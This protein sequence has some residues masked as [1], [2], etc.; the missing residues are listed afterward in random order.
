MKTLSPIGLFGRWFGPLLAQWTEPGSATWYFR[1]DWIGMICLVFLVLLIL[2][3]AFAPYVT[4]YPEQGRGEPNITERFLAPNSI[5]IMGTDSLGRDVW[6]RILFGARISLSI[7][8]TVVIIAVVL[9]VTLG[10][11]AGYFGGWIDEILMRIT[12]IFLAF[13]PLL[14]AIT[15]AAVL[16]PKTQNTIVAIALTW[17]PWYTRIVRGQVVSVRERDFVKAA[18]VIGVPDRIIIRRH[19]IPN[20]MSSVLVQAMLDL[21]A[22]ILTA[23]ALSFIGLGTQPP[24]ADWGVMVNEGRQYLLSGRWWLAIFPGAAIFFT[25]MALNLMGDGIRDASDPRTRGGK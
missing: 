23:T 22:A 24:V 10:A 20:V 15:I 2:A 12:D 18:Q 17:W 5:H 14:L 25:T 3:A 1:R 7:G 9:G 21:G 13:P 19:I 6:T 11:V 4:P 16:G 8:F